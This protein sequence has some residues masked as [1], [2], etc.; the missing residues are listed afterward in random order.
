M[1][2][3]QFLQLTSVPFAVGFAHA[4]ARPRQPMVLAPARRFVPVRVSPDREIRTVVGLRPFRPSGFVVRAEKIGDKLVVHNYGHGGGGM[5]LSWG[6]SHLAV[7]LA[8][9]SDAREFA[10]LGCG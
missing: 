4:C 6:T 5:T 9:E 10:V 8:A 7:A 2:R 3:R 1:R